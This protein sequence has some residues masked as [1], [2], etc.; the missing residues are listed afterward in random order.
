MVTVEITPALLDETRGGLADLVSA[1]LDP[2][3][4]FASRRAMQRGGFAG[5]YDHLAR[6]GEWQMTELPVTIPVGER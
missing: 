5:D 4:G 3:K 6:F 1:Y 2:D